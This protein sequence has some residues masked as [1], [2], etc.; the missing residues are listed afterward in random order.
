LQSF[1]S[2]TKIKQLTQRE[3]ALA[4]GSAKARLVWE[5]F[6]KQIEE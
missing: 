5:F 2:V 6:N 1:K 3:I 4:V